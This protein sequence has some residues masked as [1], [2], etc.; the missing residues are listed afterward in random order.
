MKCWVSH[1]CLY[2]CSL[3]YIADFAKE[4]KKHTGTWYYHQFKGP[5]LLIR[6]EKF[7]MWFSTGKNF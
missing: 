2:K 7:Q 3:W 4:Y 6:D 5:I 1:I